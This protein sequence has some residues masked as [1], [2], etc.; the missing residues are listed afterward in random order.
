MPLLQASAEN[1]LEIMKYMVENG[2]NI[3][4]VRPVCVVFACA[5]FLFFGGCCKESTIAPRMYE[6]PS[7]NGFLI[8]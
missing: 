7:R 2:A 3:N 6:K 5:R 1:R 4:P 8:D